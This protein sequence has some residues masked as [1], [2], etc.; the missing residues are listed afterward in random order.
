M[1]Q[2]GTFVTLRKYPKFV[3]IDQEILG[4][5]IRLRAKGMPDL[6]LPLNMQKKDGDHVTDLT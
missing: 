5:E 1:N 6:R 2:Y 3:L 4:D